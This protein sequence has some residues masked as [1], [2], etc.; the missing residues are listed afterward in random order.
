[1]VESPRSAIRESIM[2]YELTINGERHTVDVVPEMPLLWVLRNE[3]GLVGSKFGCGQGICGACTVHVD[4]LPQRS[5]LLPV[6][7]VGSAP[8]VTIEGVGATPVGRNLQEA[9]LEIDVMQCGYCQAGQIMT[10]AALLGRTPH[11][12]A[13]QV[14]DGMANNLCRCLTYHRIQQAILI[15]AAARGATNAA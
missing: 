13:D 9:W 14:V 5:C 10:A 11:P 7:A 8:V 2:Q 3:L 15:A 12:S 4:G 1:M 6:R